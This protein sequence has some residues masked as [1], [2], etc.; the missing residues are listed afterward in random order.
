MWI[1]DPDH[2][3]TAS[4]VFLPRCGACGEVIRTTVSYDENIQEFPVHGFLGGKIKISDPRISPAYCPKCHIRFDNIMIPT[5]LP[6]NPDE[7]LLRLN[8]L[9]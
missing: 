6:L 3:K 8:G 2:E 9:R 1:N 5:A 7:F 4:I